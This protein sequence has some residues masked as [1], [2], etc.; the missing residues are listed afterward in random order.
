[1]HGSTYMTETWLID[2]FFQ[3]IYLFIYLFIFFFLGGGYV[4]IAWIEQWLSMHM[5]NEKD[6]ETF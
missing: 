2:F 4:G 5:G 6:I 1:M 3:F